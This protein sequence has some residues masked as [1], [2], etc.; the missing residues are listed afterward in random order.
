MYFNAYLL[1]M[2]RE[3]LHTLLAMT[4][5]TLHHQHILHYQD[6]M[7]PHSKLDEQFH[8]LYTVTLLDN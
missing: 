3:D 1:H 8:L 2:D 7:M 4:V 5:S 6:R